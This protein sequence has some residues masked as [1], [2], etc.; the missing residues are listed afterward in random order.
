MMRKQYGR[1][2]TVRCDKEMGEK[3]DAMQASTGKR[4]SDIIRG[5]VMAGKIEMRQTQ[6]DVRKMK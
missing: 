5:C 3:L 6:D 2:I 4:K 1:Q